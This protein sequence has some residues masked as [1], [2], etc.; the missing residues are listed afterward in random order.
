MRK[1]RRKAS[2]KAVKKTCVQATIEKIV[3]RILKGSTA[4]ISLAQLQE[5]DTDFY[6]VAAYGGDFPP[7]MASKIGFRAGQKGVS[8][9]IVARFEPRLIM[10]YP[11][12]YAD[13]PFLPYASKIGVRSMA[14]APLG[15]KGKCIGTI[16]LISHQPNWFTRA[17]LDRLIGQ[18]AVATVTLENAA[19]VDKLRA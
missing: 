15:A 19:L 9:T 4:D 6:P 17:D 2:M 12:E 1:P 3:Q 13:S 8:G 10:D 5:G 7:P 18:A 14:A 11:L 16:Y